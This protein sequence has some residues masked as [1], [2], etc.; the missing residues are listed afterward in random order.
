VLKLGEY[1]AGDDEA[2]AFAAGDWRS[3]HTLTLDLRRMRADGMDAVGRCASLSGLRRLEVAHEPGEPA[4]G[5]IQSPHLARLE[6]L[7]LT[8]SGAAGDFAGL[9]ESPMLASLR[10]LDLVQKKEDIGPV[11]ARPEAAGLIELRVSGENQSAARICRSIGEAG[12]LTGL[13][14]ISLTC[15]DIDTGCLRDLA[16]AAH[17]SGL[18]ELVLARVSLTREAGEALARSPHLGGLRRLHIAPVG[19]APHAGE[20]ILKERF[21]DVVTVV[22]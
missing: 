1:E 16:G 8:P 22:G 11:L 6:H 7:A 20:P 18:R 12:H 15:F 9:A 4:R 2:R 19:R 21:G 14:A 17:L 10:S 13:R 3:L 5:L